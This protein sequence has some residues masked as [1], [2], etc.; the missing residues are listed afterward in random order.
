LAAEHP[1]AR[2][3]GLSEVFWLFHANFHA[4]Q[5]PLNFI[6]E[7]YLHYKKHNMFGIQG[8]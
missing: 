6:A 7:H 8:Q 2:T 3:Y 1:A 4:A 5:K